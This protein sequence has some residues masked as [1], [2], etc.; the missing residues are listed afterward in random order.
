MKETDETF[1]PDETSRPRPNNKVR[2]RERESVS[3]RP[4]VSPKRPRPQRRKSKARHDP[5]ASWFRRGISWLG[6]LI[7]LGFGTL[8]LWDVKIEGFQMPNVALPALQPGELVVLLDP[9][10]GGHDSG[11]RGSGLTEKDLNLDVSQKV[12]EELKQHGIRA[13]LTRRDDRFLALG[14][15]TALANRI[16]RCVFVSIHFNDAKEKTASGVETYFATDKYRYADSNWVHGFIDFIFRHEPP[17]DDSQ[18]LASAIQ[19]SLVEATGAPDRGVKEKHLYVIRRTPH[20]AALV[21]GGFVSN[22]DEAKKISDPK[23]RE[24]IAR[25]VADGI[26]SYLGERDRLQASAA[27]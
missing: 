2:A 17:P 25:A 26:R 10:H 13:E 16:S 1:G 19:E 23:Y 9:G 21:E 8:L 11:A 14:E 18:L 6:L 15:R 7:I 20:P 5:D 4:E 27:R 22:A 24:R 12:Q 3:P